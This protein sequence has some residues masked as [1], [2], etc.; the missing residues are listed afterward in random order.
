MVVVGSTNPVKVAAARAV[1]VRVV[2]DVDV[3]GVTAASG[4]P[5]QPWGDTQTIA[6]A[7]ARARA[8]L[9]AAPHATLGVGLEGGV[10]EADDG[11]VRTCAWCVIVDRAGREGVGGSL[12]MPLPPAAAELLRAGDE[13]GH[14][15]DRLA[16]QQGTKHGPGA[17]GLL[18]GGLIDRQGA[19]ET[20]VTYAL[21]PW[22]APGYWAMRV[23][24]QRSRGR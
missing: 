13:L 24:D 20:L 2:A 21:A 8:A 14:V 11:G 12:A 6:G 19:Y 10:V 5:A 17:V 4:V 9:A 22:L 3:G 23:D 16:A 15:M 7:R 1:L 18:T